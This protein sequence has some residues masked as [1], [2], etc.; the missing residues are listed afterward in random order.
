M[1]W[2]TTLAEWRQTQHKVR[3]HWTLP[4]LES[5]KAQVPYFYG[6]EQNDVLNRNI[7]LRGILCRAF[8]IPEGEE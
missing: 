6:Q 5:G 7:E 2:Q 8:F 4:K 3:Q 1:K